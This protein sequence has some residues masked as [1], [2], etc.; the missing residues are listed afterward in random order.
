M[1]TTPRRCG[2]FPPVE[3]QV[4]LDQQLRPRP[5]VRL[6]TWYLVDPAPVSTADA[7]D[8]TNREIRSRT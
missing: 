5:S 8:P 3:D 6:R 7:S 2:A 4:L 1:A